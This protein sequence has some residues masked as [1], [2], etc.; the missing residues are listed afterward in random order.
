M[1]Y[2]VLLDQIHINS[3]FNALN[4]YTKYLDKTYNKQIYSILKL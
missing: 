4:N 2:D 1:L 3:A